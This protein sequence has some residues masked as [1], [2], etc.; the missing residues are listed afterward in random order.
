MIGDLNFSG[1]GGK[2]PDQARRKRM[3]LMVIIGNLTVV[4]LSV[5]LSFQPGI[6]TEIVVLCAAAT[7]LIGN[8][9][10]WLGFRLGA[11]KLTRRP[12]WY[13]AIAGLSGIDMILDITEQKYSAAFTPASIGIILIILGVRAM[14]TNAK[15][16][17]PAEEPGQERR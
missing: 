17:N 14:R 12:E 9:A 6:T 8:G 15:Q 2:A 5:V 13:F 11:A 10:M 1:S 7:F 4:Y 3:I 16:Q